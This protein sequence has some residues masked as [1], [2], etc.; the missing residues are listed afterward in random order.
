MIGIV[1]QDIRMDQSFLQRLEGFTQQLH[2]LDDS[3]SKNRAIIFAERV[4]VM[5]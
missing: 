4:Q 1:V 5:S 3:L 2:L